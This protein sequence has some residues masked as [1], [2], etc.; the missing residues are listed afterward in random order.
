MS[1]FAT[2]INV[3]TAMVS[4]PTI[5]FEEVM[6]NLPQDEQETMILQDIDSWGDYLILSK[7][8]SLL[9]KAKRQ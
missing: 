7:P 5:P 6:E 2:L 9:V 1:N 4:Q 3:L 8:K